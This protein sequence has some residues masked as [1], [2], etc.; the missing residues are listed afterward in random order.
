[1]TI[2]EEEFCIEKP[3][4]FTLTV[5]GKYIQ[6]KDIHEMTYHSLDGNDKL[7]GYECFS[8]EI[9]KEEYIELIANQNKTS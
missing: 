8:R 7:S 6:R 4:E 3:N 9:T 2:W 1:M 5:N